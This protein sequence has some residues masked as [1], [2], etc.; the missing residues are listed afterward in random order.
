MLF[1]I[2][3]KKIAAI[4]KAGG[5]AGNRLCRIAAPSARIPEN[6]A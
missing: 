1:A 4:Y 3:F 2:I 5:P 6:A